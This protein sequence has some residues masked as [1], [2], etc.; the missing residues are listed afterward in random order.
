[1]IK[2]KEGQKQ[3]PKCKENQ[4]SYVV[5]SPEHDSN[6]IIAK[7]ESCGYNIRHFDWY[8]KSIF[9]KNI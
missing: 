9:D 2:E 1:M 6:T 5:I 7:C 8:G 3:C 4:F